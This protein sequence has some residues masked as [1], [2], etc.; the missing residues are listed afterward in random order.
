MSEETNV[1]DSS[2]RRRV[3]LINPKF[4]LK[5]IGYAFAMAAITIGIFYSANL[6][7]FW[8]FKQ[9]GASIGLSPDH[10][11]FR[12]IREQ[13]SQMNVFFLFASLAVSAVIG[14]GGLLL[15]HRVAG[16]LY[17]LDKHMTEVAE[18]KTTR[19]LNFR[20][21]DF[22]QEL[23]ESYNAQLKLIRGESSADHS[24]DDHALKDDTAA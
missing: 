13:Q 15:S 8:E 24:A 22:F 14:V 18:G 21:K 10:V 19:D 6:Y 17:R 20:D 16:P 5:V 3:F 9:Q 12:F 23:V 4:Q 11:F 7:F 1:H 2:N